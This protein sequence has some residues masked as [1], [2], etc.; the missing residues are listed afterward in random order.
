M[1]TKALVKNTKLALQ[2]SGDVVSP[3]VFTPELEITFVEET[4][5]SLPD[6]LKD[7]VVDDI[8]D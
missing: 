7:E 1:E 5:E 6:N 8:V 4:L 2:E 3:K